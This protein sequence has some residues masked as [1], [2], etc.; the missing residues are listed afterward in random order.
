MKFERS[1]IQSFINMF[2][3]D[4]VRMDISITADSDVARLYIPFSEKPLIVHIGE[5]VVRGNV[6]EGELPKMRE[7]IIV[8]E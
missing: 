3:K 6:I 7:L 8:P 5:G 4:V 1:N 2:S